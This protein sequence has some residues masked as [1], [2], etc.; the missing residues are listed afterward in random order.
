[1]GSPAIL[2]D[3]D[4]VINVNRHDHVKSWD[5]FEFLPGVLPAL[6]A[7]AEFQIPIAIVSNQAVVHRG[8]VAEETLEDIHAR[9]LDAVRAAGGRIDSVHYCP[10]DARERCGCRKPQ[11]GLLLDAARKHRFDLRE[12]VFVGDA[13]SDILAGKRAHCRTILVLTGRGRHSLPEVSSSRM[14]NPD[15]IAGDLME[16]VPAIAQMLQLRYEPQWAPLQVPHISLTA[17]MD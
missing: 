17:A 11:P 7:L 6:V 2:L 10:H 4:G 8:L 14:L 9:M 12:S 13:T 5:E 1:M 15:A 3:R 16:S